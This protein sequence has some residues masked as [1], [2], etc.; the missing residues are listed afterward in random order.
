[1]RRS[2]SRAFTLIELLVVIA[3]IAVLIALLLPAVQ[4]AREAARRIQCTN[5]LKQLGLALANYE[6]A[7][8]ALPPSV[9]VAKNGAGFWSNGWSVQA[10]LL[11]YIEQ[12]SSFNS[13]NFTLAYSIADNTTVSRLSIA[14]FV[15]PSEVRPEPKTS[16]TNT[17]QYGVAN[18]NWNVGDWY[19]FGGIGSSGNRGAFG[20][21]RSR[22]LAEFT[23]GLSNTVVASEVK[24]YQG[25]LTS[26]SIASVVEPNQIPSPNA[27]PNSAVPEYTSGCTLKLTAH[28]E[29]VDGAALETGFTTAWPP[30]KVIKGGSPP[31]E[32]DLV[33]VGEKSGGP[34]YAAIISRS[35][36]PGGVNSLFGDG[37]VRFMKSTVNGTTWR[38]LGSVGS[39]EV[40]SADSY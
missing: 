22:S 20:A 31:V 29:W 28:A 37:S 16:T 34:T 33:G 26:C 39:G 14:G 23:D 8:N 15:C 38:S 32:V 5:N 35:Y 2:G 30:N 27:D 11:P 18:Y 10:R 21:N 12:S 3:I 24:T 1:M 40:I 7:Q 6:G 19:V 17:S 9:V 4:A 36:H 25:V 13:I